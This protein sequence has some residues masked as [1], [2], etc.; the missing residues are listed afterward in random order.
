[1]NRF[2]NLISV[3]VLALLVSFIQPL[4]STAKEI[5]PTTDLHS[6]VICYEK[7]PE[8][9]LDPLAT[10][11]FLYATPMQLSL[12][13]VVPKVTAPLDSQPD[14]IKLSSTWLYTF[15]DTIASQPAFYDTTKFG[16]IQKDY[17]LSSGEWTVKIK[18]SRFAD[19]E[20]RWSKFSNESGFILTEPIDID[21]IMAI[22]ATIIISIE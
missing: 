15:N 10:P 18:T 20:L 7:V 3:K 12:K 14:P 19:G 6:Y 11:S 2:Q 1:M 21:P 5:D 17:A 13:F 22:P 9:R 4:E 16:T 8:G